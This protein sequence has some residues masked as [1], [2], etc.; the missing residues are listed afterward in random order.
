M[1]FDPYNHTQV[2]VSLDDSDPFDGVT[3]HTPKWVI[4]FDPETPAV[5]T[6]DEVFSVRERY[7][8]DHLDPSF[9]SW[10]DLFAKVARRE[11]V[12]ADSDEGLIAALRWIEELFG[13]GGLQDR[14]FLKAAFFRMLRRHGEAGHRRLLDQLGNLVGPPLPQRV[15]DAGSG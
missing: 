8:R 9:R 10:L 14:A 11:G 1:A 7:R 2:R 4:G 6:W 13:E 5:P 12:R 3:E 15:E